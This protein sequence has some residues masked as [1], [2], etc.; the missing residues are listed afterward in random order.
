MIWIG[1]GGNETILSY[2]KHPSV[3][4][5]TATWYDWHDYVRTESFFANSVSPFQKDGIVALINNLCP[6][7]WER[8]LGERE[9]WFG[10]FWH[11]FMHLRLCAILNRVPSKKIIWASILAAH[12]ASLHSNLNSKTVIYHRAQMFAVGLAPP[13]IFGPV[14]DLDISERVF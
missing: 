10:V 5:S 11:L 2:L 6:P 13:E 8:G 1:R 3:G 9:V 7:R 12:P 14:R 4:V